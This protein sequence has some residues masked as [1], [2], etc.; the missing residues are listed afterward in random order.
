MKAR[1]ARQWQLFQPMLA[2]AN[3][4]DRAIACLGALIGIAAT[5]ALCSA[6]H[7]GDVALPL[8]IAPMGASTVL[9]FALPASPFAQ[10]WAIIGGHVVSALVGIT[11]AKFLAPSALADGLAVAGAIAGM[12][13]LRCLHP[14]GGG[15]ALVAVIGGPAIH[16][17]GYGFAAVPAG[18]NA[19]VLVAIGIAFHR[20][21]RP[22]SQRSYP[23]RVVPV[24]PPVAG[25]RVLERADIDAALADMH[26]SFDISRDDLDALLQLAEHHAA[27]RQ[28][29]G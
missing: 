2:G 10:P 8:L 25:E 21:F 14:P 29:K 5:S 6:L 11:V 16:A 7:L 23:H 9:L 1:A 12:S 24:P 26:D 22:L 20:A 15:T 28:M 13:L 19:V 3:A 27:E 4:R 17:A 18:L